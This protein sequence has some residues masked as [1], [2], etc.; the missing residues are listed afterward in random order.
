M[1][2]FGAELRFFHVGFFHT[3]LFRN[4][5]LANREKCV[6]TDFVRRVLRNIFLLCLL[7]NLDFSGFVLVA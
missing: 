7:D 6:M 3:V 1:S 2:N 4:K 5:R